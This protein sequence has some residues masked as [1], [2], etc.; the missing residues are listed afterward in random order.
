MSLYEGNKIDIDNMYNIIKLFTG[1]QV[2]LVITLS[3]QER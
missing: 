2:S 3:L 1:L